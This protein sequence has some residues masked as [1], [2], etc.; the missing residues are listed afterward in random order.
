MWKNF[1]LSLMRNVLA[2]SNTA[3]PPNNDKYF[4]I[5]SKT[6]HKYR[7]IKFVQKPMFKDDSANCCICV[8]LLIYYFIFAIYDQRL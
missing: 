2:L 7:E 6:L 5:K 3:I 1:A 8:L 4:L